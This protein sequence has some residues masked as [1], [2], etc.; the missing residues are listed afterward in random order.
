MQALFGDEPLALVGTTVVM[1]IPCPSP[2]QRR[3]AG[4]DAAGTGSVTMHPE[5][6]HKC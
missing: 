6:T 3:F 1:E 2:I 5:E 4:A